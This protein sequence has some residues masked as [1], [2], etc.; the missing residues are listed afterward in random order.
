MRILE[1]YDRAGY[2]W[3]PENPSHRIPGTLKIFDGGEIELEVVGIFDTS[4]K[5]LSDDD[6]PR[7]IGIVEKD[8]LV[9]LDGC[10]YRKKTIA[11]GGVARSIIFAN[12]AFCGVAYD[13]EEL[14]KFNSISFSIEGLNEWL[15]ITG[16]KV[17]YDEDYKSATINYSP[18]NEIIHELT[19]GFKLHILFSY[20]L[21]SSNNLS[22]AKITQKAYLKLSSVEERELA[23]FIDI[24]HKITYLIC[25]AVDETVSISSVIAKSDSLV[26]DVSQ[27]KTQC[28]PIKV[29]YSS[30]PFSAKSPKIEA[31][32]MLFNFRNISNSAGLIFNNWLS[33]YS[34]VRPSL[35]LY[36]SAV[37][38]S[39]KY[40]DGRFLS[41]AQALETYHRRTSAETLM[42]EVQFRKISAK[43]LWSCPKI[44]RKW[45]RGRI[46]HGN[47][48]N[49]GKRIKRIIEPFKS[50]IGNA[51]AISKLTRNIV[52]TRNYLT[53]YSE[54][55]EKDAVRGQNLWDLCQ[56][57]EAIFQ[58]HLLEQLGFENVEIEKILDNNYKLKQKI[59]GL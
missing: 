59:N 32:K 2:F 5:S 44:N 51:K 10:F 27:G 31:H 42:D 12:R 58:L 16:I 36:F 6:I 43:I 19:S 22:E 23:E 56:I 35:G 18:Q 26:E 39:H 47:E 50:K 40:L 48:I 14:V 57:M 45:L 33:A 21:P 24:I 15:R 54:E 29:Y 20:S 41:L 28:V 34:I 38:G 37:S 52:N 25:F 1:K 11:F 7:I 49:L 17:N 9:T 13:K 46:M 53:H 30:L 4:I 8:G 3:L 55:L